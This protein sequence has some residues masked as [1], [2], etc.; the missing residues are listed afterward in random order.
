MVKRGQSVLWKVRGHH[1]AQ[2]RQKS[3]F[4]RRHPAHD[5]QKF[6]RNL[7]KPSGCVLKG[8][9]TRGVWDGTSAANLPGS[10][11]VQDGGRRQPD[12][13]VFPVVQLRQLFAPYSRRHKPFWCAAELGLQ[14]PVLQAKHL[15]IATLSADVPL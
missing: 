13:S 4:Q 11:M 7:S 9:S 12:V 5:L 3:D 6:W 14:I 2:L 1:A 15:G 8:C 10:R